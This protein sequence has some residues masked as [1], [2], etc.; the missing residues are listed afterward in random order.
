M[1]LLLH[2]CC[3]QCS[4]HTALEMKRSHEVAMCFA[5]SN[6]DT[7]Y[8]FEKRLAQVRKVASMHGL[9][10]LNTGYEHSS[11]LQRVKGLEKEPEGGDRCAICYDFRL[12]K[13]AELAKENGYEA[14]ASTLTLSPHKDAVIINAIG[15]KIARAVDLAYIET[16][17]KKKDGFLKSAQMAKESSLYRQG[18]CGCEFSR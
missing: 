4:I 15:N 18:Y 3:G 7:E 1:K 14:F 16:D 10:L 9:E 12:K 5:E 2:S 13:A 17:F 11:W 8:E 6:L